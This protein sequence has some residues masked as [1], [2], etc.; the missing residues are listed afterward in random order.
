MSDMLC[1]K[2]TWHSLRHGHK[3]FCRRY[4]SAQVRSG[5][6]WLAP[7]VASVIVRH[8]RTL[9]LSRRP[10]PAPGGRLLQAQIYGLCGLVCYE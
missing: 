5:V 7:A 1:A 4:L 2:P 3:D 6:L 9:F 10:R 8:Q